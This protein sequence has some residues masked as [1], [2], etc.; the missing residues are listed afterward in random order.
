MAKQPDVENYA[1]D[2]SDSGLF[3]KV[4]SAV[5][6]AGLGLVYKS[7][8]LFYVAKNPNVPM[9]IRAGV[10]APLGYFISPIDLIPD[11][12]PFVGYS[13]DAAAIAGAMAL[14]H[15]YITDD[16]KQQA[17]NT[18]RQFFGDKAAANL[19]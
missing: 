9:H 7:L 18:I 11:I 10:I 14:A 6:S 15:M 3:S 16:I 13:D 8:Q 4:K 1:G 19:G 5:K 2:Y 17:K 12:T